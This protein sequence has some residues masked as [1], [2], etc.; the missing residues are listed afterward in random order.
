MMLLAISL[1][2]L[3]CSLFVLWRVN[4]TAK[5][6][7]CRILLGPK[8]KVRCERESDHDGDHYARRWGRNY[9]LSNKLS[10]ASNMME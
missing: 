3:A 10:T 6:M 9:Y 1:I 4:K 8:N 5:M 7:Q 2:S